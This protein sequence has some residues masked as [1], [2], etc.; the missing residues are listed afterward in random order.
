[1]V[2]AAELVDRDLLVLVVQ[3]QAVRVI[4]VV[5]T[6]KI[7]RIQL[8]AEVVLVPLVEMRELGVLAVT[9]VLVQHLQLL[10][11]H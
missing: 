7:V 1:V 11:P 3:E 8:V 6:N 4:V 2:Q 9:A 10:V 5:I